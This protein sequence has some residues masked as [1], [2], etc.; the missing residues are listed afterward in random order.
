MTP[1]DLASDL[2]VS[3][4][5]LR[6]WLRRTFP[7]SPAEKHLS[8]TIEEAVAEAARQHFSVGLQA[9][10]APVLARTH[11]DAFGSDLAAFREARV[12]TS[13]EVLARPS[14]VPALPG[15]YG[16]WF[17]RL[18]AGVDP[19][20]CLVRDDLTLLYT[21]ISPK[22]PPANGRPSSQTVRDRIRYH[23][24]GNAEG[25]TL[26]KTLGVLL[27]AELGIEL[28]RVGS[29]TRMTFGAGE[30]HLSDWMAHHALVAWV[31]NPEPWLLEERLIADL[32][33]PL[34]LD[35]N[36]H[37]AF[38]PT[39]RAARATAVARARA[40]PIIENPGIGGADRRG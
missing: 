12:H 23:Y 35:G 14:P 11:E 27:S 4:Q 5:V 28:R 38:H 9:N 25:S 37:N 24:T 39:L 15:V 1:D 40:L 3:P 32:D 18:P 20:R 10:V 2:G 36:A 34:N 17:R 29:G 7:R 26:R 16:W 22:R 19:A 21:G 33:V 6:S 31:V 30:Q 8:W 13:D